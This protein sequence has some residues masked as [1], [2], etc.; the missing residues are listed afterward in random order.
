M[1][2]QAVSRSIDIKLSA[3]LPVSCRVPSGSFL[4][5]FPA[6]LTLH[7]L[8]R[9]D[10]KGFPCYSKTGAEVSVTHNWSPRVFAS[11]G[12]SQERRRIRTVVSASSSGGL[13]AEAASAAN[14]RFKDAVKAGDLAQVRDLAAPPVDIN[15]PS[16]ARAGW[17]DDNGNWG[18]GQLLL[19]CMASKQPINP[20]AGPDTNPT[21][22]QPAEAWEDEALLYFLQHNKYPGGSTTNDKDRILKRSRNYVWRNGSLIRVFPGGRA[23]VV[24]RIGDRGKLV[25]DTHEA[26]GHFALHL[27]A[28]YGHP[29]V[30]SFLLQQGADTEVRSGSGNTALQLACL[31]GHV[32]IAR[33]LLEAGADLDA[34]SDDKGTA[35]D[36]AQEW[37]GEEMVDFLLLWAAEAASA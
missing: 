29:E 28:F 18:A 21:R 3:E 24:P 8:F 20:R 31:K 14:E 35:Y 9:K 16:S 33:I 7:H 34:T 37:G 12:R 30:T 32:S 17:T 2:I 27:G 23:A 22:H 6:T 25:A 10:A 15:L 1:A 13:S 36:Y 5:S 11:I 26:L 4:H 19:W